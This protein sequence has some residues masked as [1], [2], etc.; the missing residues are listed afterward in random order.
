MIAQRCEVVILRPASLPP[1]APPSTPASIAVLPDISMLRCDAAQQRCPL[2]ACLQWMPRAASSVRRSVS[3]RTHACFDARQSRGKAPPSRVVRCTP[4]TA[5]CCTAARACAWA[6]T[7]PGRAPSPTGAV[8]PVLCCVQPPHPSA[9]HMS[10]ILRGT[11]KK[12][13]VM[14]EQ[15][16]AMLGGCSAARA[17]PRSVAC[18]P[19]TCHGS[20]LTVGGQHTALEVSFLLPGQV[21]RSDGL[22]RCPM[23]CVGFTAL[24]WRCRAMQCAEP[25]QRIS[26]RQFS[27]SPSQECGNTLQ[28]DSP[29]RLPPG[30]SGSNTCWEA[31]V[32]GWSSLLQCRGCPRGSGCTRCRSTGGV[33]QA[34]QLPG[35][36]T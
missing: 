3:P 7:G 22:R 34:R 28:K 27:V 18:F 21:R 25:V 33:L 11:H 10:Q 26:I 12:L 13:P 36:A 4:R 19:E 9:S 35:G 2:W 24:M 14:L 17:P 30:G 20:P 29:A 15:Q 16:R 1:I 23:R 31:P 6:S 8:P 32:F 5:L